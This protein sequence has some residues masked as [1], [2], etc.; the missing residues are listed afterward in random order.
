VTTLDLEV[1]IVLWA[2]T[3]RPRADKKIEGFS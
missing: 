3:T 1:N 2:V